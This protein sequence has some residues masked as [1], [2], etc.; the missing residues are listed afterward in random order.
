MQIIV[1]DDEAKVIQLVV[2]GKHSGLPHLALFNFAIAQ[3][4][5]DTVVLVPQL[6]GQRHT[7][8]GTDALTQRTGGKINAGGLIHIGVALQT[9]TDRA[10]GGQLLLGEEALFRQH[11]VQRRAGV[12]LA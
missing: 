5:I 9:G 3:N 8:G 11:S 12:T 10:E 2:V 7:A 1:I 4:G 6:T